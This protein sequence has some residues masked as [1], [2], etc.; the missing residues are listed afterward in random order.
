MSITIR[1]TGV[2]DNGFTYDVTVEGDDALQATHW[3]ESSDKVTLLA[4]LDDVWHAN[5]HDI[6]EF[7]ALLSA[8]SMAGNEVL[9]EASRSLTITFGHDQ[10]RGS[11]GDWR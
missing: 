6:R 8:V 1:P 3:F 9:V 4:K 5:G 7:F 10:E 11:W 2:D